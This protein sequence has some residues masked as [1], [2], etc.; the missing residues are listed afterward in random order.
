M[1]MAVSYFDKEKLDAKLAKLQREKAPEW[2]RLA[3]ENIGTS[4]EVLP[5]EEDENRY[6]VEF[7][8]PH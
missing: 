1:T 6:V 4:I 8:Y 3:M 5:V 2:L 7:I